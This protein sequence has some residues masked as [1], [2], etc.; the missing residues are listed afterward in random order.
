M[1]RVV[2]RAGRN[3]PEEPASEVV[4]KKPL[5]QLN[6]FELTT[7][8][9]QANREQRRLRRRLLWLGG[10]ALGAT[11]FAGV[12]GSKHYAPETP[13][14]SGAFVAIVAAGRKI[15]P[16]IPDYQAACESAK[17]IRTEHERRDELDKKSLDP[18][19]L[20]AL[21]IRIV[22]PRQAEEAI[23][24]GEFFDHVDQMI[25]AAMLDKPA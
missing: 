22:S 20:S 18:R 16:D 25:A 10:V 1:S 11:I 17:I 7:E 9:H 2:A 21:P 6:R 23:R 14:I 19:T 4:T 13:V 15:I 24:E 12:D 8:K 3:N 5:D